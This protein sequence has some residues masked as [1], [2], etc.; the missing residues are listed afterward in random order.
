MIEG[1]DLQGAPSRLVYPVCRQRPAVGP[2]CFSEVWYGYDWLAGDELSG[3]VERS[4]GD[5][6]KALK[7]AIEPAGEPFL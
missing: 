3:L 5:R 4:F 1:R 7:A 6:G 2:P